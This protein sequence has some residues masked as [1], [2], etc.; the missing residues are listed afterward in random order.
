MQV[1]I[2]ILSSSRELI[3]Q[4]T[5]GGE[6]TRSVGAVGW[7]DGEGEALAEGEP[8]AAAT[9]LPNKSTFYA[10]MEPDSDA[11]FTIWCKKVCMHI[12]N[13]LHLNSRFCTTRIFKFS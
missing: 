13:L 3:Q 12:I 4:N 10:Q 9:D 8:E 6:S 11:E 5:L 2:E 1:P 7:V